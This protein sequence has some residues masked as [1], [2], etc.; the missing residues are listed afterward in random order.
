MDVFEAVNAGISHGL[1]AELTVHEKE[2]EALTIAACGWLTEGVASAAVQGE[3]GGLPRDVPVS[4]SG[5]SQVWESVPRQRKEVWWGYVSVSPQGTF[6]VLY[7]PYVE[8]VLPWLRSHIDKRPESAD[9]QIGTFAEG[10]EIGN[11]SIQLS[12]SFDEELPDYV[13]LTYRLDEAVLVDPSTTQTEHTRLL[14]AVS[15][16]CHRY[17]VVF[18]H[19]SYEHSVGATELERC[20]RGPERVPGRN[21]PLWRSRLRGYSWL[22]VISGDVAQTLG[23]AEAMVASGAFNSVQPLPNSALLLQATPLF[24]EYRG[25][26]VSA[27]HRTVRAVLVEGE[28]RSPSPAPG[29]PSRHMVVLSE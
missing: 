26:P 25:E 17:N 18:G 13:K 15:W 5:Y 14:A 19:F 28:W 24:Q 21:T 16:A 1:V 20:L 2:W 27:V 6:D 4:R 12:V 23:G 9:V 7:N 3:L 22:M 10:G 29:Q 11:S 8:E